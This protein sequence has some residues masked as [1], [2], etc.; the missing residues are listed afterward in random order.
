MVSC[1]KAGIQTEDIN[2]FWYCNLILDSKGEVV[3]MVERKERGSGFLPRFT[4]TF[5][6]SI[7]LDM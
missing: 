3:Y 2:L 1:F 4:L 6:N 5:F 7:F